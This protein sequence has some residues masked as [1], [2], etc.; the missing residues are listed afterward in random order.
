MSTFVQGL[1]D[2]D[3]QRDDEGHRTYSAEYLVGST[4]RW[5]GPGT[6]LLTPGLP[7]IGA[8]WLMGNEH[9]P[10]AFCLPNTT[11]KKAHVVN[12]P[13]QWWKAG[14]KFSTKPLKRCQD[15]SIENP[16]LEPV[17]MSGSFVT[18]TREFTQNR[19]GKAIKSSSHEMIR[20]QIVEFDDSTPNVKI[21]MNLMTLPLADFAPMIHSVNDAPMWGLQPRM[22]KLTNATWSRLVYGK[23]FFYF[24]VDYDFDVNYKT[25]D[26]KAVDEGTRILAPGGTL[27]NP[28]HFIAYKDSRGENSRVMLNGSGAALADADSPFE[29]DIEVYDEANFLSLSV[30][31]LLE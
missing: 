10:W 24:T 11:I 30:P 18:K 23:C 31:A 12:E 7:V 21:G 16:L 28:A 15:D 6:V 5:D 9:D 22:I 19:H 25:F 1:I 8:E 29:I 14:F 3:C 13:G 17:R 26:R 2:W 20:G 27:T 4:D